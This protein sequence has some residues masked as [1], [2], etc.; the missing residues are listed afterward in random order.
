MTD[1][2][3]IASFE[4][5]PSNALVASFEQVDSSAG[6]MGQKHKL[7]KT[8]IE[9]TFDK[10][11]GFTLRDNTEGFTIESTLATGFVRKA[12]NGAASPLKVTARA[13]ND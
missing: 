8:Q 2:N 1:E 3:G 5:V 4:G 10:D 13:L 12:E 6:A 9:I 11:L 7:K